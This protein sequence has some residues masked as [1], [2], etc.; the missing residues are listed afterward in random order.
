MKPIF[1]YLK[2]TT[3]IGLVYHKDTSCAL[4]SYLYLDYV[5]DVDATRFVIGY[6]FMI[7][8]SLVSWKATLHPTV[9]LSS[10]EV[11]YMVITEATKERIWLKGLVSN[12]GFPQEK[13]I[14]LYDNLSVIYLVMDQVYHEKT[15]HID[16]RY[17]FIRSKKRVEV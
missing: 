16:I 17:H 9:T 5:A 7:D 3:V 13:T 2:G 10:T 4:T 8:N 11:E 6:T 14:I 1:K 15:K 12:L